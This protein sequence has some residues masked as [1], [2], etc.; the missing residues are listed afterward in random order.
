MDRKTQSQSAKDFVLDL[1]EIGSSFFKEGASI[2]ITDVVTDIDIYEH[3]DKPY[4][5]G[6]VAFVDSSR[7]Y[8]FTNFYGIEKFT[9][10]VKLPEASFPT[11]EKTFYVSKVVKN[12]RT[13]DGQ[14]V[15]VLHILENVAYF[16]QMQNI[17]RSYYGKGYRIIS[18]IIKEY[19]G[20]ELSKPSD[21][22]TSYE[23]NQDSQPEFGL[24]VP[25]LHPLNAAEWIKERLTTLLLMLNYT[26]FHYQK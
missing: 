14:S 8:E 16:S 5:T 17:N 11:V 23:D 26:Y 21:A 13:S 2:D 19:L 15:I 20:V 6:T 24:V 25:N 1:A 9:M 12:I 10:R 18:N 4:I 3:L 7:I 22:D